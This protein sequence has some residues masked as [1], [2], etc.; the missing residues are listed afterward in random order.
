MIFIADDV[1]RRS[2]NYLPR[3]T[4]HK[5]QEEPGF[6]IDDPS[7]IFYDPDEKAGFVY[8]SVSESLYDTEVVK[9]EKE[10][11]EADTYNKTLDSSIDFDD[12]LDL[13]SNPPATPSVKEASF[14]RGYDDRSRRSSNEQE[15]GYSADEATYHSYNLDSDNTPVN[16]RLSSGHENTPQLS[17]LRIH[18]DS[19]Y[20]SGGQRLRKDA[21][22]SYTSDAESTNKYQ[23]SGIYEDE[24]FS[25]LSKHPSEVKLD[26]HGFFHDGELEM[27]EF[28][29]GQSERLTVFKTP[30][31]SPQ[32]FEPEM[33]LSRI[34]GRKASRKGEHY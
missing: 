23:D 17:N 27:D 11:T 12:S 25:D 1:F 20:S 19:G 34:N 24:V 18:E 31:S 2:K 21:E 28:I 16:L 4:Q 6:V 10:T 13:I 30:S 22:R 9:N 8:N 29:P 14:D 33:K 7:S 32:K 26:E 3:Y 15:A 5:I